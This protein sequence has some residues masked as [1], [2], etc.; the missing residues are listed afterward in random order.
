MNK[1]FIAS[2]C[3]ILGYLILLY[4]AGDKPREGSLTLYLGPARVTQESDREYQVALKKA[5]GYESKG[6]LEAA[7]R[8]YLDAT[9][10]NRFYLPS[11][12][13][14]LQSA[15]LKLSIGKKDEAFHELESF[16][17]FA[18]EELHVTPP[19]IFNVLDTTPEHETFVKNQLNEAER[20]WQKI[21]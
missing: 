12:Y 4:W 9:K 2:S 10:I 19:K 20:F 7:S 21:K 13:P 18:K 15:K 8:E 14:L 6:Q 5:Q 11:Y 3:L 16:I 1:I 17:A